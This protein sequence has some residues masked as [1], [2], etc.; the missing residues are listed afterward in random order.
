MSSYDDREDDEIEELAEQFKQAADC[1]LPIYFDAD[2]Y[3]DVAAYLLDTGE[4]AYARKALQQ[5]IEQFPEES[6]FHLQYAK[7]FALTMNYPEAKKRFD[8]IE[9]HFEL[10][11]EFYIEK[12]LVSHAFN[13]PIDAVA[14][15][16]KALDIDERV[17]EAHLLLVHEYLADQD[18]EKAVQHAVR[19][20]QLDELAAEDLKIVT[21]DFHSLF[22]QQNGILTLFYERMTKEMPLCGSLWS[23]LGLSYMNRGD[24]ENALE[25]FQFQLSL[26]EEDSVAYVN[27]AEAYFGSEDYLRAIEYFNIAKEKCEVLQFNI[28]IGRCYFHLQDYEAAMRYFLQAQE[29]DPLYS[30]VTTDIT[31]VFRAQGKFDEARAYLRLQLQNDPQNI[32]AI[33]EL[34]DLLNPQKDENEIRTLCRTALQIENISKYSFLHFFVFYCCHTEGDDLGIEICSDYLHD[35]DVCTDV[36]YFMAALHIVK[37]QI[38]QG[39]EYLELALQ[40]D[41]QLCTSDFEPM[42]EGMRNIPEVAELFRLYRDSDNAQPISDILN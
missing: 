16:Q 37:G 29:N 4:L 17:P 39:C 21:I 31:H 33:E 2:D 30:Y 15:L 22:G 8:Y 19:A 38:Q 10:I 41:P 7:Y 1:D 25:A 28:Q 5:A 35:P 34:I 13:Q 14:M 6:Y 24:Y 12:V 32:N 42:D 18:V 26:D 23:G 3:E 36:H 9:D 27:L 20:I 40:A 11:P